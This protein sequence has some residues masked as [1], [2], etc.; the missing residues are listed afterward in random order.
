M[1]TKLRIILLSAFSLLPTCAALEDASWSVGAGY[2][3]TK[4]GYNISIG[5]A[6]LPK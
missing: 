3:P 2:D 4:G 6:P 1:K 5:K